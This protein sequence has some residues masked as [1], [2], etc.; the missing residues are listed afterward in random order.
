M[1]LFPISCTEEK[2]RYIYAYLLEIGNNVI[3]V[4]INSK[5]KDDVNIRSFV[6]QQIRGRLRLGK[7]QF[8]R[9]QLQN[10]INYTIKETHRFSS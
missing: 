2:G 3:P 1:R 9:K 6:F 5:F 8:R 4:Y 10:T 7:I